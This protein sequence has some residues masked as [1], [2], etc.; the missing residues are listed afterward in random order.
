MSADDPYVLLLTGRPQSIGASALDSEFDAYLHDLA[1]A[2]EGARVEEVV[3][4]DELRAAV[5]RTGSTFCPRV[6]GL[7][8]RHKD[9][10]ASQ[11]AKRDLWYAMQRVKLLPF[12]GQN[13]RH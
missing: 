6:A 8:A 9:L 7:L 3:L 2:F 11:L 4:L 1:A 12:P 5:E 13:N 10:H